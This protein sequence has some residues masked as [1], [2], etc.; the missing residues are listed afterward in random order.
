MKATDRE[1]PASRPRGGLSRWPCLSIALCGALPSCAVFPPLA[2]MTT[3]DGATMD[4]LTWYKEYRQ[5]PGGC[6]RSVSASSPLPS[7]NACAPRLHSALEAVV[8]LGSTQPRISELCA[9]RS[10]ELR[11]AGAHSLVATDGFDQNATHLFLHIARATHINGPGWMSSRFCGHS[12]S[13][14][15]LSL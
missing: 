10:Y 5:T 14:H 1:L 15:P 4:R 8:R 12:L 6:F 3:N 13:Q 11:T 2:L 7:Q 9:V